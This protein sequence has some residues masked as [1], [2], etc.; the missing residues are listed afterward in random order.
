V[1]NEYL[2]KL[3]EDIWEAPTSTKNSTAFTAGFEFHVQQRSTNKD[4]APNKN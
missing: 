3:Q 4:S 1:E 2:K